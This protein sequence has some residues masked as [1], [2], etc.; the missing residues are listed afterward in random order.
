MSVGPEG[1]GQPSKLRLDELLEEVQVRIEAVRGMRDRVHG[2]LEAVLSVGRG[3]DLPQVLRG[4]IEAA[5]ALVDAEY[6]ALGV[7]GEDQMLS[8]FIP[9]GVSDEQWAAIGDLPSGHGLLGELIRNPAPLRLA[10]LSKHP[11]SYGF[12]PNHPPMRSFLGVPIRVGQQVFGNLYLTEK[13]G[14]AEFDAED[15]SVVSTLAVAAGIAIE[16]ARLY[17]EARRRERWSTAGSEVTSALLSGKP[18]AQVLE[19]IL[20]HARAIVPS[21]L[22]LITV[23]AKGTG[24]LR[25]AIATGHGAERHKGALLPMGEGLVAAA[26][27][28]QAPISTLD[29]E[30]EESTSTDAARWAGLG[31]GIAVPLGTG[32]G[33]RGVLLLARDEAGAP[34]AEAESTPLISFAGQT[35][36]AMELAERRSDAEEMALLEDRDR[37]ARDLHDLAIQRLF[38]TGM[39]LQSAQRFID[40]P[41]ATERLQRAVD[42]LDATIKIIRSTI[43][44]LRSHEAEAA[45]AQSLRGAVV[46]A[47]QDSAASLGFSPAL[48]VEGLLDTRTDGVVGQHLV[49]VLV[50]A[51]SNV[52][53]H[54]RARTVDVQVEVGADELRLTV[55]DDGVGVPPGA[56][57]SGLKNLRERAR[58]LN[59][60]LDIGPVP[61]GGTRLVWRVPLS[62]PESAPR[63]A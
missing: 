19:L 14:A 52:A 2:L 20:E 17:E 54:A 30:G 61:H 16:N 46:K 41:Q 23:P 36:L 5:T 8:E 38:A 15:E 42:D 34:F 10:D 49:A 28:G 58:A 29:L 3:L 32:K 45:A 37:I 1:I 7:I 47:V 55:T 13:R 40:H 48:R 33:V 12:P 50:E 51:L 31:P 56:A 21:D 44:G 39:T 25:T 18:R 26:F 9:V 24:R 27:E 62:S 43:F 53:R 6:G 60:S 57:H 22:G 35:A 4:I 59:G 63:P 11:V